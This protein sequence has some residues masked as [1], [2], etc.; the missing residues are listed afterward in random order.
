[1]LTVDPKKDE[2]YISIVTRSGAA[3]GYDKANGKKEVEATWVRKTTEQSYAFDILKEK[4]V[5]ME[6]R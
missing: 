6:V 2:P 1:M 5:F 3:T 4:K